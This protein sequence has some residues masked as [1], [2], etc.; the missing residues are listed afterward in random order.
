[1]AKPR[2]HARRRDREHRHRRP[3]DGARGGEEL[4]ARRRRRR[5]GRLRGAAR[6]ADGERRERCPPRRAFALARKAFAH[7]AAYDGAISNWLTARGADGER[8]RRFPE[9]F[10]LA[11]DKVQDLRYG[12]NPHQRAAFY[13]DER[14]RARHDRHLP[15]AAGQGAVVQQHRRRRRGLGMREDVRRCRPASSSSTRIRAASRSPATP[16]E[17][18][19]K[20]FATDPTSAFG[21]II[22]FNRPV[23]AATL[24][25][26]AAQFVEVLIAPAYTR[27][28]ARGRSRRRRTC[29]CSSSRCQCATRSAQAWDLKRVGG[30]LL[31]QTRRR[32]RRARAATSRSSRESRRRRPRSPTCCSPGGSPG[33][34]SRTPSSIARGGRTLGIGAGPDEPRRLDAHRGDQGQATPACRSRDRS[35]RPTPSFRSATA[36][37][38]SPTTARS[39]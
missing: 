14:R 6:R 37:T 28:G 1:M 31:V 13:R 22:A 7:T 27:R 32:T 36:S 33:S 4:G 34:S 29:A 23:D 5:P 25:A 2:L 24:E 26:V 8:R 35:S 12:E 16:L 18:Y 20:A 9:R 11:G 39:R 21:G 17:A 10:N 15:A 38:S 30:G 3:G 19:R